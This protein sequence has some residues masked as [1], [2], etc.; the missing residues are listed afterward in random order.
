MNSQQLWFTAQSQTS[1]Q[2]SMDGRKVHDGPALAEEL[3][4]V[5]A[6]WESRLFKIVQEIVEGKILARIL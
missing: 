4:V 3:L 6:C 2:S 1:Q 5:D